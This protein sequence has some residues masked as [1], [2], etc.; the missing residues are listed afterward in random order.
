MDTAT[1]LKA[2]LALTAVDRL[3]PRKF[4]FESQREYRARVKRTEPRTKLARI[5]NDI[6]DCW[7][8]RRDARRYL[9]SNGIEDYAGDREPPEWAWSSL[10][11][12]KT[13]NDELCKLFAERRALRLAQ[14]NG[15]EG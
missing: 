5:E 8:D 11:L 6:R 2:S 13:A 3:P 7:R 12:I 4:P 10:D 14:A 1:T 15:M 9:T